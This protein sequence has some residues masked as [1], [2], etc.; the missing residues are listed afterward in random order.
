MQN[1]E[2]R[3]GHTPLL[4]ARG[5]SKNYGDTRA[6]DGLDLTIAP[7]EVYCLLGPN[8]AGKTTTINLFLGF[9]APSGGQALVSGL[10]V[11][12]HDRETKQRLAYI[13]EQVMLYRNLSGLENLEYFAA[14]GGKGSLGRERL[15]EVL[16]EA[17]LERDVVDRRVSEYSK[18]MRQK[19]GIAIAIAKEADVL[20]LDE[21]TSGLDPKAANEFSALVERLRNRGVAV[22]MATHD[23]FR[24]KETGTRVGIMRYGRLVTELSTDEIGHADLERIY[25]EHMHD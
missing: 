4:E 1:G 24:A 18:G 16:V 8:G 9:V 5:L 19:V 15:T 20:L 7:G 17:G 6:L 10:D 12:T 23:L 3:A 21:P 11:S 14:L 25:L 2:S 13:P 22:L